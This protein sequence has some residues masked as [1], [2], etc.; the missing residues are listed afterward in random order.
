[1]DHASMS[2][3]LSPHWIL[4]LLKDTQPQATP[5]L[6]EEIVY[7]DYTMLTVSMGI[8]LT[9]AEVKGMSFV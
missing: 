1:M 3:A 7:R 8:A 5:D 4:V 6:E 2:P 9:G